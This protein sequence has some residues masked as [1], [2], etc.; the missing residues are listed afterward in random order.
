METEDIKMNAFKLLTDAEYIYG[1]ASDSSQGK[2]KK[3]DLISTI[4]SLT[5]LGHIK[6]T[7][8]IL[9]TTGVLSLDLINGLYFFIG[10]GAYGFC[11]L[12]SICKNN[13]PKL[14][15]V[16]QHGY[17]SLFTET[18]IITA[19]QRCIYVNSD[20]NKVEFRQH[21]STM[22]VTIGCIYV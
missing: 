20:T 17:G 3:G 11:D 16:S 6:I 10:D 22:N 4:L 8:N 21:S 19:G 13:N 9:Y 7:H 2:M 15:I 14:S 1:E 18:N 12:V 5:G